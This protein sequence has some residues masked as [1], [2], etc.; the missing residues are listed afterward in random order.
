[1]FEK[2][3]A[4][5]CL[6]SR[7][8]AEGPFDNQVEPPVSGRLCSYKEVK[9]LVTRSGAPIVPRVTAVEFLDDLPAIRESPFKQDQFV[10]LLRKPN[11]APVDKA[12]ST[13][14][15]DEDGRSLGGGRRLVGQGQRSV[16]GTACC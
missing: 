4:V 14:I 7:A 3:P 12:G 1:Q 15:A 2:H 8:A 9:G 10:V 16:Q 11:P 5:R 13:A 6:V